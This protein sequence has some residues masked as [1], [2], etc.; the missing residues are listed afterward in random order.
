MVASMEF[1]STQAAPVQT[2]SNWLNC[3]GRETVCVASKPTGGGL[4]EEKEGNAGFAGQAQKNRC[5]QEKYL[6]RKTGG[7]HS[8]ATIVVFH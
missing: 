3:E 7:C 4:R 2:L 1:A 8:L 6:T 5:H